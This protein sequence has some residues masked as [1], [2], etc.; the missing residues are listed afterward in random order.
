MESFP[1]LS[2]ARQLRSACQGLRPAACL[3]VGFVAQHATT[4][5]RVQLRNDLARAAGGRNL[6]QN[7]C[8]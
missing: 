8:L 5:Q 7:V 1:W 3:E 6:V 4:R 2:E